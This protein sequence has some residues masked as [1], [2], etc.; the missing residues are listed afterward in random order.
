M[1]TDDLFSDNDS[2]F[3]LTSVEIGEFKDIRRGWNIEPLHWELMK[4]L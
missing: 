4:P 2:F 1:K 3:S